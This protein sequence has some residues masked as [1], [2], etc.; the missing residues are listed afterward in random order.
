MKTKKTVQVKLN[1]VGTA[2]LFVQ[3][4]QNHANDVYRLFSQA[5][6]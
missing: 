3:Y 4:P 2:G 6:H 5:N 1:D